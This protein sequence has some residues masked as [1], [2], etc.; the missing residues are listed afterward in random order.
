VAKRMTEVVVKKGVG[1]WLDVT[2]DEEFIPAIERIGGVTGVTLYRSPSE[3]TVWV[4]RRYPRED[5]QAEIE[6]L[7]ERGR[8]VFTPVYNT[9]IGKCVWFKVAVDNQ[10]VPSIEQIEGIETM[11]CFTPGEY[12]IWLKDRHWA[13]RVRAEIEA[14]VRGPQVESDP[15][16]RELAEILGTKAG[17]EHDV[18]CTVKCL[19]EAAKK[20]HDDGVGYQA[21]L[22]A[23]GRDIARWTKTPCTEEPTSSELAKMLGVA[24]ARERRVINATTQMLEEAERVYDHDKEF[25]EE[26]LEIVIKDIQSR[27]KNQGWPSR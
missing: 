16:T 3:Y 5:V 18:L 2:V 14:L 23:L 9:G 21:V 6:A 15:S 10:F 7:V 12:T 19:L 1:H 17:R 13:D 27:L 8:V 11:C 20:A 22:M 25:Y 4:D 24:A 26:L